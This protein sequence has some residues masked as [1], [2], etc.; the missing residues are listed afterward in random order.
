MSKLRT[1]LLAKKLGMTRIFREDG[2][3]V[4]VTVLLVDQL[5]VVATKTQDK[6]GYSAVQLGLGKVKVKN[7]TQ[8]NR[9]H[10][11]KAKVEPKAKLT[12]FRVDPDALLE[13]GATLSAAHFAVGQKI[14]VCGISKGKG[15]A[16]GMKRWNYSGLE[17]SHG[18]SISHRSLGSTGNRQDPG[19]T[20]K[21]KKMAGHLGV[22]RITTLNLEIAAVDPDK[23]LIMIKGA[24][25]G[26]KGGYVR[27]RDAVKMPP[28]DAAFP[29][30]LLEPAVAG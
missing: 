26:A 29:A 13:P 14:D 17:A 7:V 28:K 2:T 18:V 19:R 21:N 10:F 27:V 11:A 1:G 25:P 9:G 12:E 6:D 24:V 20:F 15:F 30:V 4:P 5:Q 8:P 16:G 23:G 22:E 3:H